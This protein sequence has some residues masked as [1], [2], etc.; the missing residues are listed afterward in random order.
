M[1]FLVDGELISRNKT[2]VTVFGR[3]RRG[4]LD[5]HRHLP[6]PWVGLAASFAVDADRLLR[7][8]L[9][10]HPPERTPKKSSISDRLARINSAGSPQTQ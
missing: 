6:D 10:P 8:L 5:I 1:S 2:T 4:S 9:G 3:P 7:G